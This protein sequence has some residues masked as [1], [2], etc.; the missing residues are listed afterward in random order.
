MKNI[1]TNFPYKKNLLSMDDAAK[2]L[3]ISPEALSAFEKSY[4]K[5]DYTRGLS[6]NLFEINAKQMS[7]LKTDVATYPPEVNTIVD[8][9]VKELI[10]QT[11]VFCYDGQKTV[12]EDYTH[13]LP[14]TEP[15]MADEI[16]ALPEYLR[17]QLSGKLMHID[18]PDSGKTL[19]QNW[20]LF[21]ESTNPKVK[22][23]A[24][25]S[26][27]QGLDILDL[28]NLTY[29][30][31][32]TNPSSMGNWL[33]WMIQP[34]H[35]GGFFKI[36]KTKII[37]VPMSLLQ[38]TKGVEYH[39]L[40]RQTLDIVDRYCFEVFGLDVNKEYFIKTGTY[41]SKFDFRNAHI[42]GPKE[43]RELGE[44]LLY[45]HLQALQ[46]AHFDLS[47]RNQP[48]IYG[49]STTTEWVVREFIPDMED[50]LTIYHGLPLRTEYRVFVDFDTNKVLGIHPYWDEK[51]MRESFVKKAGDN[52]D[53]RHDYITFVA[54]AERLNERYEANKD[55]IVK[56]LEKILPDVALH[57]QYSIDIMQNGED[58]WFIDM[59]VANNSAFYK[60]TVPEE[61][62]TTVY[63]NWLP[64]FSEKQNS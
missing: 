43:V 33:P 28:D 20:K 50:N 4:Q 19:L 39:E 16:N 47:G 15:V 22:E 11:Q 44:Y 9:I 55:K 7:E 1:F 30:M 41:S 13:I 59:A 8:R 29:S 36:P 61:F 32:D 12:I 51:V 5:A 46:M 62:R 10:S 42:S 24:Y 31:I 14:D 40:T 63:E 38:L 34:I 18:F 3:N 57:D 17:P 48:I 23:Y 45:I 49:V 58:F 35:D 60:E 53:A 27:R 26:F 52:I 21:Q 54:N 25:H 37:K 56:E 2:L 64:S 6:D